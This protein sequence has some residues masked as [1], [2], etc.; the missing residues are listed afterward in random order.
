MLDSHPLE[1]IA[2]ELEIYNAFKAAGVPDEPARAA[3]ESINKAIDYR[4]SLHSQQLATQA[5]IEKVHAEIAKVLAEI[6]RSESNIIKW[7]IGAIVATAGL[8]MTIARI[9]ST[10]AGA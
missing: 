9:F 5:D 10:G 3:V 7:N 2:M 6:A 1:N 8:A 4:Y